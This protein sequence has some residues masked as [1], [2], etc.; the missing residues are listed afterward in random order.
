MEVKVGTDAQQGN[1]AQH[2]VDQLT[3]LGL[4]VSLPVPEDLEERGRKD[5]REWETEKLGWGG[6]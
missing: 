2:V 3:E 6:K 5:E 4:Q 1:G